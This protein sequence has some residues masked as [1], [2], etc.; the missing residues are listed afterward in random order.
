[1]APVSN[2]GNVIIRSADNS[3]VINNG[4]YHVPNPSSNLPEFYNLFREV[5][6]YVK[7]LSPAQYEKLI[8]VE[9]PPPPPTAEELAQARKAG[10][11][12]ELDRL[13]RQS[14][15]PLRAIA[16]ETATDEDVAKLADLDA[17][18]ASLRAELAGLEAA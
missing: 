5:D 17:R 7:S 6:A 15:R 13:D 14:V 3:Y 12:A 16:K 1:M 9:D 4:T 18:A 8:T 11:I 2:F 10:I